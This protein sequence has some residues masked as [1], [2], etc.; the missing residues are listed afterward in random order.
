MSVTDTV[1]S[2]RHGWFK[3]SKSNDGPNCVEVRFDGDFVHLRDSKYL[4]DP[5]NDP[6]AQPLITLKAEYWDSFLAA[7]AVDKADARSDQPVIL[8]HPTGQVSVR[9]QDGTT[10]TFTA[11]EW[12]AFT[13]GVR[14]GEFAAA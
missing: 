10:L 7:A 3:S 6:A 14:E 11:D 2:P 13:A 12:D 8:R 9:A 5:A 4:R 1:N